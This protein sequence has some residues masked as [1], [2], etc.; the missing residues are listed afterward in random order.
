[1]A[2]FSLFVLLI[3]GWCNGTRYGASAVDSL[4][5][6]GIQIYH[7]LLLLLNKGLSPMLDTQLLC[8]LHCYMVLGPVS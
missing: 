7:V 4:H 1:M 3:Y 2:K 5:V 8:T 6:G